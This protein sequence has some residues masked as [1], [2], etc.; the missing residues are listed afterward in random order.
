[1]KR[2]AVDFQVIPIH[3]DA[4]HLRLEN[5]GRWSNPPGMPDIAPGFDRARSDE[6]T[7]ETSEAS[8]IRAPVDVRDA[9]KIQSAMHF[10]PIKHRQALAWYYVTPSAPIKACRRIGCTAVGLVELVDDGRQMLINRKV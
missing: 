7:R 6:L 2:E 5:W 4:M 9:I 1:M 3:Q 8:E 10:M